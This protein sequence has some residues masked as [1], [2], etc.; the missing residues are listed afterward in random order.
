MSEIIF[1]SVVIPTY[2]RNDLLA[3]CLDRLAPT[4]QS[5]PS[6]SY[7]VIVSDD[8]INETA[9]AMILEKYPWA[10]WVGGP[11]KGPAANRNN[12][13]KH[14]VGNW[15]VF[16]DDDCLPD[17]IWLN[18]YFRGIVN[19]PN[20]QVFEGKTICKIGLKSPLETAPIN[21]T[22]GFLWSCN[23]VVQKELFIDL[24]GFNEL[25][26][27]AHME[28][29]EFR[30]RIRER[31][32]YFKFIEAAVIDHPPRK[33]SNGFFLAKHHESDFF[34]SVILNNKNYRVFCREIL[35]R[36]FVFRVRAINNNPFSLDSIKA[37]Y[38]LL[39]E[40]PFT[41]HFTKKWIKK[42]NIK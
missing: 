27:F 24:N 14:A 36:I 9:Q 19:S 25:F 10:K 11:K 4:V 17:S 38:N 5:L 20:V 39:I 6:S 37:L 41:Y 12:G 31:K 13:A 40:I 33:M 2:H 42:Y 15:L 32:I 26:P 29:V 23:L 34:Y 8:G 3:F 28:D 16:T 30:D 1:L 21:E 22:G 18:S 7:E 35:K